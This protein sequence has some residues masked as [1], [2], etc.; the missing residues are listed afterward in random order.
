M[1]NAISS[2]LYDKVQQWRALVRQHGRSWSSQ[3]AQRQHHALFANEAIPVSWWPDESTVERANVTQVQRALGLTSYADFYRW[4]VEN[5]A[6]FWETAVN[7][8]GITFHQPYQQVLDLADGPEHA[9]WLPGA[10]LNIVESC[11][12][13]PTSKTALV[14]RDEAGHEQR[15]TYGELDMLTQ[16]VAAGLTDLGLVPGDRVGLYMPLSAEAVAAYLGIIRAGMVAVLIAD[17]FSAGE[18][19]RRLALADAKLLITVDAYAYNG[20]PLV[21]YDRVKQ[22]RC[23]RAVVVAATDVALRPND[24]PWTDFLGQPKATYHEAN[25]DDVISILFSSGTTQEPKAIPWTYL[26]P[27]KCATDAHFHQDVQPDDVL[28][29]TTGMGWMMGPWAIFAALMNRATLALFVGSGASPQFGQFVQDMGIT[30]LGT[31]PSLV[32]VWRSTQVVEAYNWP[33]RVLSSTGEPSS[34]DDY[35]Y[36]MWLTGFRAPII[37]YCGGTEIGGGYLTGSTAQ[38]AAPATFTT[39]TLGT[40]LRFRDEASGQLAPVQSGEVFIV[41]PA[42][43]LSQR[44]L[45]RDHHQEYY[46]DMPSLPDGT[47]LRKHGD[48]YRVL[49]QL[50]DTTFYRSGG[51]TDDSMN[52][53]GI[54][55]SAVEIEKVLNRHPAVQETAAVAVAPPDG[56]PEQL[57]VHYVA[58]T[59]MPSDAL[60]KE[61]Q[62]MLSTQLNPLFRIQRLVEQSLLPR[63]ASNKLQRRLLRS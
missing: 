40:E 4:S 34:A 10:R 7:R 55:V 14:T 5:K 58:A 20:K 31:I 42:I 13:A 27:I 3:E 18:L 39:P 28:T 60:Q 26:T 59:E 32:R 16:R 62:K 29:W 19:E 57:V 8:L 30:V 63:T 15:W 21:V 25:P 36:L 41:P 37:E 51:R 50:G 2:P 54:K 35:F 12:R 53:G 49:G 46:A 11:F 43:G 52:L 17:S 56:G 44:L 33:V 38:P 1:E 23:T 48:T 6:A 24:L 9:R 61:L 22:A 45:N 47:L